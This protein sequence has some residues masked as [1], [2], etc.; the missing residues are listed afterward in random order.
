MRKW[1][2]I[3]MALILVGAIACIGNPNGIS[4]SFEPESVGEQ[5]P[6]SICQITEPCEEKNESVLYVTEEGLA[7]T[8]EKPG[9]ALTLKMEIPINETGNKTFNFTKW[10]AAYEKELTKLSENNIIDL[11]TE[12]IEK[13]SSS[14]SLNAGAILSYFPSADGLEGAFSTGLSQAR[15][16]Y[17]SGAPITEKELPVS[18]TGGASQPPEATPGSGTETNEP[19]PAQTT[20]EIKE[21]KKS[22]T[23]GNKPVSV[24]FMNYWWAVPVIAGVL[25]LAFLVFRIGGKDEEI[26]P[27]DMSVLSAQRRIDMMKSLSQKNKTLTDLS[28]EEGISLPTTKEHLEKLEK[29][30]FVKKID[31]GHKW[32]YYELTRKGKR[33]LG[34]EGANN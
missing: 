28:K 6:A 13:I 20:D 30:G 33:I 31:T 1:L 12:E 10:D 22:I 9:D 34:S 17:C 24:S 19:A 21:P 8:V 26:S 15:G 2:F 3:S 18:G 11:T 5:T 29:S 4:L 14:P 16:E 7:V 27:M 25:I 32:K 23:T